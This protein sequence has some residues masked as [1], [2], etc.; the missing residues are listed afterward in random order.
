MLKPQRAAGVK[1]LRVHSVSVAKQFS[2]S[3]VYGSVRH[4]PCDNSHSSELGYVGLGCGLALALKRI[5]TETADGADLSHWA[6]SSVDHSTGEMWW[7]LRA[8]QATARNAE[9]A[10]FLVCLELRVGDRGVHR[11]KHPQNA[12]RIFHSALAVHSEQIRQI[13]TIRMFP[14]ETSATNC[15]TSL[16]IP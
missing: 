2:G 6:V 13:C 11:S 7:S 8:V 4:K 3:E 5:K 10:L 15:P 16:G 14:L 12:A 9:I 1:L